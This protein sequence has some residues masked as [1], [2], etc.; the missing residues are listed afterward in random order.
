MAQ[1]AVGTPV[2]FNFP[3]A[4]R[5]PGSS[6]AHLTTPGN[7]T[8]IGLLRTALSNFDS[9]TYSAANLDAMTVNDMVFAYRSIA[10]P[11]T[12]ADYMV[13]QTARSS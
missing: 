1:G 13:A 9:F 6:T 3:N 11:K 12:I 4:T 2:D 5:V 8:S 7:Y 10:D